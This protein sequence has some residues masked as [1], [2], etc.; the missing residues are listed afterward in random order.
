[1]I[2]IT[3]DKSAATHEELSAFNAETVVQAGFDQLAKMKGVD[4]RSVEPVEELAYLRLR[5][6]Y[7][8]DQ[9]TPEMVKAMLPP[10]FRTA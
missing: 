7:P 3:I 1:M 9:I 8:A 10:G 4:L 6:I 2:R 5:V